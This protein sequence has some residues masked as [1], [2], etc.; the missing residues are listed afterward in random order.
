MCVL[1]ALSFTS[2]VLNY[3]TQVLYLCQQMMIKGFQRCHLGFSCKLGKS[4]SSLHCMLKSHETV[5]I[6]LQQFQLHKPET[7]FPIHNPISPALR[8]SSTE[9]QVAVVQWRSAP[10]AKHSTTPRKKPDRAAWRNC[11]SEP[12]ESGYHDTWQHHA[13]LYNVGQ[14]MR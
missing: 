12:T 6:H 9:G 10:A 14:G 3:L 2:V 8:L 1:C 4:A 11:Q 13:I 7:L 5:L